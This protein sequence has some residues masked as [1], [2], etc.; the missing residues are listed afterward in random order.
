MAG[1]LA[2]SR[3]AS[4]V[5]FTGF[6]WLPPLS[7]CSSVGCYLQTTATLGSPTKVG[8]TNQATS[9]CG[10]GTTDD[11]TLTL[12]SLRHQP[13]NRLFNSHLSANVDQSWPITSVA[14]QVKPAV[15][16]I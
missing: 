8:S 3:M 16:Y 9:F 4:V 5:S 11:T 1:C 7:P 15:G 12:K 6:A 2:P 10:V 13:A 14:Q